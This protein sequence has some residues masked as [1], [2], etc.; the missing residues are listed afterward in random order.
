[1]ATSALAKLSSGPMHFPE[2]KPAPRMIATLARVQ[3]RAR[4][5]PAGRSV[6]P[7]ARMRRDGRGAISCGVRPIA[8]AVG[9]PQR[10]PRHA[11]FGVERGNFFCQ[12][13]VV[14]LYPQPRG[15]NDRTMT[16]EQVVLE[17]NPTT[18]ATKKS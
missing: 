5:M 8:R 7:A 14:R 10:A 3:R 9:C 2:K 12:V 18:V 15:A 16:A 11:V 13:L 1:M 4:R 17:S 6:D